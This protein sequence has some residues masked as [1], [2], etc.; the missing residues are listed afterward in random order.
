MDIKS[1]PETNKAKAFYLL[2]FF[3]DS[4]IYGFLTIFLNHVAAD[5]GW[6]EIS[7]LLLSV[8]L[9]LIPIVGVLSNVFLSRFVGSGKH[10]MN[11][12]HIIMP[13]QILSCGLLAGAAFVRP[14]YIS[15]S[16]IVVF[17]MASCN[18]SS[19]FYNV[20]DSTAS[21]IALVEKITFSSMRVWG[22][23]A[24]AI[25]PAVGGIIAD[26]SA[27]LFSGLASEGYAAL[28]LFTIPLYLTTYGLSFLLRP[29][30]IDKYRLKGQKAAV[31]KVLE[32]RFSDALGNRDFVFFLVFSFFMGGVDYASNSLSSNYWV[33]M[34]LK[35]ASGTVIN[36]FNDSTYGF[37]SG[38]MCVMEVTVMSLGSRLGKGKHGKVFLVGAG[39][40]VAL[41]VAALGAF[42]ILVKPSEG[43]VGLAWLFVA[44][45]ML[46]GV[47]WGLYLASYVP[48][49]E[50]TLGAQLKTKGLYLVTIAYG[51][52][53]AALQFSY[54]YLLNTVLGY[55]G[56]YFLFSAIGL[57]ALPFILAMKVRDTPL[58]LER[59]D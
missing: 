19:F 43:S 44:L 26:H 50:E 48:V 55:G 36:G 4:L 38:L 28:F 9:A 45:M 30:D 31:R 27:A 25:G 47:D 7:P 33:H 23:V 13:I 2:D 11:I 20:L 3:C 37:L 46:R 49:M 32:S 15:Y 39:I 58:E 12:I 10:N 35:D 18:T 52:S 40:M 34:S 29:A 21:D 17:T 41:R 5:Q 54:P 42:A 51:I 24:Y 22:S 53:N 14:W 6:N 8:V 16:L 59:A 57:V 1:H 56:T